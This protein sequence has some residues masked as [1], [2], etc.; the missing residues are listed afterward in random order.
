MKQW[1]AYLVGA[2]GGAA[3]LAIII[4][5]TGAMV[6][7]GSADE[8][9]SQAMVDV[10]ARICEGRARA[11]LEESGDEVDLK[12]YNQRD[13]RDELARKFAPILPG[14]EAADTA[15]VKACADK[16]A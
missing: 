4:Y 8:R 9:V 2:L 16:F 1:R 6:S 12:G 5:A 11:S 7:S 3:A 14:D 10:Q 13:K 15:V